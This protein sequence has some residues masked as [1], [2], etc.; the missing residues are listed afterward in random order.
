MSSL[1]SQEYLDREAKKKQKEEEAFL[2]SLTKNVNVIKKQE[3]EEGQRAQN[4]LCDYFKEH[5]T[6]PNGDQCEFSHDL[7]IA[8]NVIKTNTLNYNS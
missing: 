4:V 7:N 6:C 1:E 8:F 3:I 5:G 2:F